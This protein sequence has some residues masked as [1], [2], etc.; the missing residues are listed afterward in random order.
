MRTAV[1]ETDSLTKRYGRERGIED[2]SMTVEA[3]R[4]DYGSAVRDGI[5]PLA[6]AGLAVAGALLAAAGGLL[7]DR[8]EVR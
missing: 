5:D 2:V 8:R 7:L 6:F 1:I 3:G 4:C